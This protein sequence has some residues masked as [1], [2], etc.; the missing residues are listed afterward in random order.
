MLKEIERAAAALEVKLQYVDVRT[1]E[2]IVTQIRDASMR[3]A[4]AVL[5][6]PNSV[7]YAHRKQVVDLAVKSRL[8]SIH[9]L[10]EW[11][12]DGGLMS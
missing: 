5:V 9:Y 11:L 6:L 4:D 12:E 2:E 3:L 7:L 1:L 8:P 10:P